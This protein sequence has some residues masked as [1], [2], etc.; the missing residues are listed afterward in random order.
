MGLHRA[1]FDVTGVDIEPQPHYP[2]RF[3]R[4]DALQPP[5]DLARFDLIWASP[6]CPRFS[7]VTPRRIREGHIDL[8]SPTRAL[9][10]RHP[11]VIENVP[12]APL[13]HDIVL[14]GS[15]F[16]AATYRKRI[17]ETGIFVLTP[18]K[19]RPFGPWS[20]PGSVG[21]YGRTGSS[22]APNGIQRKRVSRGTLAEWRA[23]MGIEWM[24]ARELAN[25]VP[26][27]YAELI[28]RAALQA[29]SLHDAA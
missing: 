13:R 17:F 7:S 10:R 16:G 9:L 20:R 22:T 25:A 8:V 12:G 2:F 14:T 29:L 4:A 28:G 15:M 21:V 6:P 5:F 19:G 18:D 26:P 24:T 11:Y 3:V 27:A 23:A 1:G